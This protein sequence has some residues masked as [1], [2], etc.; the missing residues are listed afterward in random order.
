MKISA[1]TVKVKSAHVDDFIAAS[2]IHQKNTV[3]EAGN[4][5]FDF[6]QS[7]SDPTDFLFYEA[8][9]SDDDIELHRQGESYRTW[10]RSVDDWMATPRTG[11][12]YR[13]LAPRESHMYR[14]PDD[15]ASPEESSA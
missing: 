13:P 14:Y 12:P 9:D 10:R 11:V 7:K 4:L 15:D 6:L 5:R 8:Y 3:R 2:L 1:V